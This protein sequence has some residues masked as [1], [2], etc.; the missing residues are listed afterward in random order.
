MRVLFIRHAPAV[1]RD[2]FMGNDM[3]RPLLPQSMRKSQKV[4]RRYKEIYKDLDL[5]VT[6]EALRSKQTAEILSKVFDETK[7]I[8]TDI[9]NP[10]CDHE[11]FKSL[12][13]SIDPKVET[14]ALVGHEPDISHIVG[15]CVTGGGIVYLKV[16]K[17]GLVEMEIGIDAKGELLGFIS[18]RHL[19]R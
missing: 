6:S 12:L 15:K 17:L 7:V 18:P 16:K 1:E 3:D 8:T 13:S 9:I 2:E 4:F 14:L 19:K 11:K 10:G 5:I